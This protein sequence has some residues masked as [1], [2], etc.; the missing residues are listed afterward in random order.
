[1]RIYPTVYL[2]GESR[3]GFGDRGTNRWSVLRIGKNLIDVG[4]VVKVECGGIL[5]G[6][7]SWTV[8]SGAQ[9]LRHRTD[10]YITFQYMCKDI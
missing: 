4:K 9:R 6:L 8:A 10:R 2:E 7:R 1:V 5:F 3:G